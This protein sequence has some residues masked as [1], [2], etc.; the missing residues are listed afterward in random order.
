MVILSAVALAAPPCPALVDLPEVEAALDEAERTV[1]ADGDGDLDAVRRELDCLAWVAPT[2]LVG[3]W[4]RLEA[5]HAA[6]TGDEVSA[7][8][9]SALRLDPRRTWR[10]LDVPA[11][12][13]LAAHWAGQQELPRRSG[14]TVDLARGVDV[15]IDGRAAVGLVQIGPGFHLVQWR[16]AGALR[17]RRVRADALPAAV[18]DRPSG[19]WLAGAARGCGLGP[20]LEVGLA[21]GLGPRHREGGARLGLGLGGGEDD[22]RTWVQ[23]VVHLGGFPGGALPGVQARARAGRW[24]LVL[25]ADVPVDGRPVRGRLQGSV[26]LAREGPWVLDGGVVAHADGTVSAA[27]FLGG[28]FGPR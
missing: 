16:E 8:V 9:D 10:E 26:A 12:H 14:R 20:V 11:T 24:G 28:V 2:D 19:C 25:G 13:P 23:A 5:A 22:V 18:V 4:L 1:A 15:W 6:A 7:W 3:R 21:G 17:T 27:A